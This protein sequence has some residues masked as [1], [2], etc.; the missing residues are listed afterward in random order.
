MID[1]VVTWQVIGV[2]EVAIADH[3]GS[4]PNV[5]Q[6]SALASECRVG[7]MLAGKA[8]LLYC[9]VG[10][11]PRMLDILRQCVQETDIP[12]TTFLPTHMERN[13]AL[14]NEGAKWLRDGGYVDLTCRSI[15]AQ[16]HST[17]TSFLLYTCA[18]YKRSV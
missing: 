17:L 12:I 15:K 4:Q 8:G 6:I 16:V 7:G 10:T 14:I 1:T 18:V 9:H 3:R 13:E 5:D 11:S 2:G